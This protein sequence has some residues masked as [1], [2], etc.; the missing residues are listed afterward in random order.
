MRI[1]VLLFGLIALLGG[2]GND[3]AERQAW[4]SQFVGQNEKAVV[5]AMGVPTRTYETGGSK[6]VAYIERRVEIVP[7]VGCAPFW[8]WPYG[9]SGGL[10]PQAIERR[11]ETTFEIGPDGRVRTFTLRGNSC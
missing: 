3:I 7:G 11:C 9:C 4:L 5:E 10:P 6:F 1:L 8:G 2:C